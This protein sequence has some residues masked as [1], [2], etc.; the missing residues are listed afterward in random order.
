MARLSAE[1]LAHAAFLYYVQGMSQMEVAHALGV[2][3]SNVSRMLSAAR[4]QY[5]VR[6]EISYPL[7]RD[8]LLEQRLLS[9]FSHD[10]VREVVVVPARETGVGRESHGLLAVGQAA[11]NWLDRNL[12]DGQ[13]L[14]LSWGRTTEAMVDSA[15]FSRRVDV[16]VVQVAGELSIDS[17]FS[18][19]DLVRN[20]AEKL[21]GRYQ[22][23]N[24]P[25]TTPDEATASALSQTQQVAQALSAARAS[26]VAVLGIGQ[27]GMGSSEL[28]LQRAGASAAELKEAQDHGAVGQISGR[29]YDSEGRQLDLAVNRRILSLD[30]EDLKQI[31]TVVGVASGERKAQAVRA[32]I[33][34]GLVHVLVL[35]SPLALAL[36]QL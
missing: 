13:V 30:L 11:C 6:F 32:A 14:G 1:R 3:R 26:D 20:L 25:A 4:E 21:G 16:E 2:T 31:P 33:R 8:P 28:F 7:D 35:D 5:I 27:Y 22:Y 9:R 12:K 24:A 19:H 23:F 17:R 10:G 18:G 36:E 34:G 15:H 29:F